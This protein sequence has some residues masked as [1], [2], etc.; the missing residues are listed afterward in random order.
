MVSNV[1]GVERVLR[2]ILG[3]ALLITAALEGSWGAR[4]GLGAVGIIVLATGVFRYCPLY[5]VCG[6]SRA[7]A[8]RARR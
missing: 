8:S 7:K 1:Y 4:L 5:G 2:L 6:I 3:A